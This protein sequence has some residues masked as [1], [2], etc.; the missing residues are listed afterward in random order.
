MVD[1]L[2]LE[3]YEDSCVGVI[4]VGG[5][6]VIGFRLEDSERRPRLSL[7]LKDLGARPVFILV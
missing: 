5:R 7:G 3:I 4:M 1:V 2:S 6:G